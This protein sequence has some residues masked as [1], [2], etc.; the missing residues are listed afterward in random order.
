ME[1]LRRDYHRS[2]CQQVLG[3]KAKVLNI[4]D[5]GSKRSIELTGLL[6]GQLGF[7]PCSDPPSGQ[8][9]GALFE[10]LTLTYLQ[11][12]FRLLEHLRPGE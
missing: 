4:A 6:L 1:R 10:S 2:I 9:A 8:E 3:Y 11:K 7:P 5:R 12:A